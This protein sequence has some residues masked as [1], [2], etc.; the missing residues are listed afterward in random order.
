[1]ATSNANSATG[2]G[3]LLALVGLLVV[4]AYWRFFLLVAV[5]VG[6]VLLV[7]SLVR[8]QT[9]RRL[10]LIA[11]AAHRRFAGN[12]F[13]FGD[14]YGVIEAIQVAVPPAPLA[15]EVQSL[16]L[17]EEDGVVRLSTTH[18]RL[19]PPADLSQLAGN[20]AIARFLAAAAI[21]EVNDLSVEAR[22]TQA[23]IE[24]LREISWTE[25]AIEKLTELLGSTRRTLAKARGN[26]LLEPSI[27]QLQKALAAFDAEE[28]KL[29]QARADARAMARKLVDF[30]SDPEAIRPIL[31]FDLEQLVDPG[32]LAALEQSFQEVVLLNDTFR[33]LSARKLA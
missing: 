5:A 29:R 21:T 6:A 28:S 14:R 4:I 10:R 8:Q 30:L 15:L 27:P 19:P 25:G 9:L 13:R 31:S 33:E 26:E 1:M 7:A 16:E 20:S 24:C 22:A 23:A 3:A 12:V 18:R 11:A 2:C 17:E 32:R